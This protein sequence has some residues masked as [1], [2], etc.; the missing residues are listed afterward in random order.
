M[1][2]KLSTTYSIIKYSIDLELLL[3]SCIEL[4]L[5]VL[6]LDLSTKEEKFRTIFSYGDAACIEMYHPD[7]LITQVIS[8]IEQELLVLCQSQTNQMS[9]LDIKNKI[10]IVKSNVQDKDIK[11]ILNKW[12]RNIEPLKI[13]FDYVSESYKYLLQRLLPLN[14]YKFGGCCVAIESSVKMISSMVPIEWVTGFGESYVGELENV[15]ISDDFLKLLGKSDQEL[16]VAEWQTDTFDSLQGYVINDILVPLCD[17][18]PYITKERL[19]AFY[20]KM[21]ENVYSKDSAKYSCKRPDDFIKEAKKNSF[22]KLLGNLECNFYLKDDNLICN[23]YSHY[24]ERVISH[25]SL[26]HVQN[27]HIYTNSHVADSDTV[28]GIYTPEK[29]GDNFHLLHWISSK[30]NNDKCEHYHGDSPQ[31]YDIK[32][33]YA[34]KPEYSFYF[35]RKY[36]EDILDSILCELNCSYIL[37]RSFESAVNHEVDAI[38]L[39]DNKIV[40]IEAKT[41]LSAKTIEDVIK[42]TKHLHPVWKE[43]FPDVKVE[44]ITIAQFSDNLDK[45]IDYFLP[46][47]TRKTDFYTG[48][49]RYRFNIKMQQFDGVEIKFISEPSYNKMRN[50]L[51]KII[52]SK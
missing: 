38:I 28:L 5:D 17:I 46:D 4:L 15:Y 13:L 2:F 34:L 1:R 50:A 42:K 11:A 36:Y 33:V 52:Q 27:T 49:F 9:I 35:V 6:N 44:Y 32:S 12:I 48:L 43:T 16:V 8:D 47:K 24:F 19:P 23:R 10:I 22:V 31:N 26:K 3:S 30:E 37:N 39:C 45:T 18:T 29:I 14:P 41:R 51:A 40:I 7:F 20:F 21:L 25:D